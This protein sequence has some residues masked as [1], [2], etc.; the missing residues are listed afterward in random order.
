M[1][2]GYTTQ[3]RALFNEL[4][5]YLKLQKRYVALDAADKLIVLLTTIAVAEVC[6][7]LG[8][9]LLFFLT[10]A[11]AMWI[12]RLADNVAVGFLSIAAVLAIALFIFNKNRTRW[13][14]VPISRLVVGLFS[15]ISSSP[16]D[17]ETETEE[18][19]AEDE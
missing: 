8:A 19:A 1:K 11:L 18:E 16:D 14:L 6:F 9:M 3:F 7:V 13:V 4:R 17:E 10:V 15:S 12:G 5:R 2:G